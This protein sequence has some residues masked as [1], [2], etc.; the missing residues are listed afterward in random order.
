MSPKITR[1]PKAVIFDV[2]G[3]LLNTT[4]FIFQAYE[5][6]LQQFGYPKPDRK[7]MASLIG[8]S[9]RECYRSLVP[10]GD[11]EA[12]CAAHDRFQQAPGRLQLIT[13]YPDID[14]M[15]TQ[16]SEAGIL[17]GVFS[18]RS[19][20]LLPSLEYAGIAHFF[21]V[22]I[23]GN[24]VTQHK[25]HPEGLLKA[26]AVLDVEPNETVMIGDAAVDIL[27]GKAAK[28][29]ATIGVTYGFGTVQALRSV[30]PDY[31]V[32]SAKEIAPILLGR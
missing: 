23:R 27:S 21:Q 20:T 32:G 11:I 17:L 3:M 9:L 19:S 22:V 26:L 2:D 12:L 30:K 7:F 25:P 6:T 13:I 4:E 31:I 15:L 5:Y 28:V 1:Q 16:L 14:A 10:D 8:R 29:A 18:S 24:E